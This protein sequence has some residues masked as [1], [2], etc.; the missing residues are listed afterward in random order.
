MIE[1]M[2]HELMSIE[3]GIRHME[4]TDTAWSKAYTILVRKRKFIKNTIRKLERY[5]RAWRLEASKNDR[6]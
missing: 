5:E 2:K 1:K 6:A 3:D 4:D